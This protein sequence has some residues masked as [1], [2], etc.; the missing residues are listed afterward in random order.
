MLQVPKDVLD[1]LNQISHFKA[2]TYAL[3]NQLPDIAVENFRSSLNQQKNDP[4]LSD[5]AL[6]YLTLALAESL[7]HSGKLINGT[8]T[9]AQEALVLLEQDGLIELAATPLWK[10]Q[11]L[12]SLGRYDDASQTL[13]SITKTHPLFN[14]AVITQARIHLALLRYEDALGS[15]A[16]I[17]PSS[18]QEI[19]DTVHLLTAEI[20][21][22]KGNT[23]LATAALEKI[24]TS[25]S[26]NLKFREYLQA[27]IA[28]ADKDRD[29]AI[30]YFQSLTK[31]PLYLTERLFQTCLLNLADAQALPK[32]DGESIDQ[33]EAIS[34]LEKFIQ[35]YPST[36]LLPLAFT[37]LSELLP[38]N[39]PDDHPSIIK[40]RDWSG[41]EQSSIQSTDLTDNS[42]TSLYF[43]QTRTTS[44]NELQALALYHLAV[45]S[46]K[47][48]ELDKQ[49]L[50][51]A[52]F[53]RLRTLA[54]S[55]SQEQISSI[56]KNLIASSLIE[57]AHLYLKQGKPKLASFSLTLIDEFSVTASLKK[58]AKV[59]HGLLLAENNKL[60]AAIENFNEARSSKNN[61]ITQTAT[62]NA[63]IT[64]LKANHLNTFIEIFETTN[65]REIMVALTL[66]RALWKSSQLDISGREELESFINNNQGHAREHEARIALAEA[67]LNTVPKDI[68]L[69]KSQLDIVSPYLTGPD[70]QYHITLIRIRAEELAGNWK[71]IADAIEKFTAS[72][73]N[74][75]RKPN[76]MLQKGE[77]YFHNEDYNQA[78]LTFQ[79]IATNYP[80]SGA[81]QYANFYSA[82]SARLVGTNQAKEEAIDLFQAVIDN[83]NE[84]AAEARI[85]QSRILIDLRQYEA[86]EESLAPLLEDKNTVSFILCD[87]GLLMADCLYRQ[88]ANK[89]EKYADAI[90]LYDRLL[91]QNDLSH[92]KR[93]RIH[94]LKGKTYESMGDTQKSFSAYYSVIANARTPE[95]NTMEATEEW[96]WFYNCG[97]RALY[98]LET[99]SRWEAAVKLARSIASFKGPRSEE[100]AQRANNIAI[101]HMIWEDED[102]LSKE[103]EQIVPTDQ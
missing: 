103:T 46:A 51:L 3:G 53:N 102:P 8:N 48:N 62:I 21:L 91:S 101:K 19:N 39:L 36:V 12:I 95:N 31:S 69:A 84:L 81:A 89:P 1:E 22:N 94:F 57:T 64:A 27:N 35:N 70:D 29:K 41:L 9:A 77:A 71:S 58:K 86:A 79:D 93:N 20:L 83:K 96:R 63:G 44:I 14:Q 37:K 11:A 72:F 66:E 25:N 90:E 33:S 10:A 68:T 42:A 2:G 99:A 98:M 28:L 92:G 43:Y 23:K 97:F 74:D 13:S 30:D 75:S 87:A 6:A 60:D 24:D 55:K 50:S 32:E 18:S 52:L 34:T 38:D 82:M 73:P 45:L 80:E 4:T 5:Q 65:D 61:I 76:L 88:G 54:P 7:I 15:L 40:L 56:H 100:A 85:Q 26:K 49:N 16:E 67:C 47:S 17:Q 78:R 59:I